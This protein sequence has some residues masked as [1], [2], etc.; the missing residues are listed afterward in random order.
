MPTVKRILRLVLGLGAVIGLLVVLLGSV[1][2]ST[3][4]GQ[5]LIG[6]LI[7]WSLLVGIV[8]AFINTPMSVYMQLTV[9]TELL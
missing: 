4:N 6:L 7:G 2:L 1:F 9:P 8:L 5:W 3:L